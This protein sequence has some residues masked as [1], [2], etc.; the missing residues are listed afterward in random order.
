VTSAVRMAWTEPSSSGRLLLVVDLQIVARLVVAAIV[1]T[2][3]LLAAP[4]G[5]LSSPFALLVALPP[6]ALALEAFGW[7]DRLAG[8]LSPIRPAQRNRLS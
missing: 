8:R 1:I 4:L 6:L 7:R 3:P 2:T 5:R